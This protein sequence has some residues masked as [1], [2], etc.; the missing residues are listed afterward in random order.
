MN[1]NIQDNRHMCDRRGVK[2]KCHICE[3]I[4]CGDNLDQTCSY[5]IQGVKWDEI[6][7]NIPSVSDV[8]W[9]VGGSHRYDFG[10]PDTTHVC[11]LVS[12]EH[13]V[14]PFGEDYSNCKVRC[15]GYNFAG[16]ESLLPLDHT[17]SGDYV[18]DGEN[19]FATDSW[20][21]PKSST[22]VTADNAP[23]L[24][25]QGYVWSLAGNGRAGFQDGSPDE[26]RFNSPQDIASDRFRNVFVADT[27]NNVI[28]MISSTG[29]VSTVAGSG[30]RGAS[31]GAANSASFSSPGAVAV[32]YD[33]DDSLVLFVA[34]SANHRIRKV[35]G[36]M[37]SSGALAVGG[38]V[39]E[40]FAGRC[41]LGTESET[42]QGL[43][44]TP[45]HGFADGPGDI[46]RFDTPKGIS[47]DAD[48]MVFVADTNNH[49]IRAI[50][51]NGTVFTLAGNLEPAEE[52]IDG[53]NLEGCL[54]PCWAGVRGHRDGNLTYARFSFPTDVAVGGNHTVVVSEHHAIRRVTYR[55]E[56]S[57]MQTIDSEN[58]VVTLAGGVSEGT[59]D[60][61]G[62]EARFYA[63][64][65]VT[66][67]ADGAVYVADSVTCRLRRLASA[68]VTAVPVQCSTTLPDVVRPSGCASYN[69]PVDSLD[70]K[71]TPLAAN[72]YHNY[73]ERGERTVMGGVDAQGRRIKDCIGAPPIDRLTKAPWA[74]GTNLAV[75]DEVYYRNEDTGYG[76]Q[77]KISCPGGCFEATP[78]DVWGGSG[79]PTA[80]SG[81]AAAGSGL[82]GEA[83]SLCRA[84]LHA[85]VINN[86]NGG[87]VT[88]TLEHNL[89]VSTAGSRAGRARFGMLS[90]E[91]PP[92][93]GRVFAVEV[94]DISQ[95]E[96]QTIAGYPAANQEDGCGLSNVMPP[97]ESR[98]NGPSGVDV[99]LNS[100]L[101][102]TAY[103]YIAD[104]ANH[105]VRAISA[106]CSKVCENGGRCTA[107][108]TCTC[109]DGWTGDD[110]TTPVCAGGCG[111]R[112]L[113]VAPDTCH[114]IP[115]YSGLGAG[116]TTA[117]C[118]Q[119][120]QHGSACVAPDTCGCL[121]GWVD[122]NCTT[123]VCEQTCGN[124][125]NCTAPSHCAC[126]TDW[127]GHD[128]RVPVCTQDCNNGGFCSAPDTCTCMPGWSGH[129]CSVAVCT[130]GF[131]LPYEDDVAYESGTGVNTRV[132]P[133]W[134]EYRSCDPEQWC[135]ATNGFDCAQPHR[136][137]QQLQ[138]QWG[139]SWRGKTGWNDSAPLCAPLEIGEDVVS[140]FEYLRADGSVTGPARYTPLDPFGPVADVEEGQPREPFNTFLEPTR[141]RTPPYVYDHD[142]QVAMV[143]W[144][145]VTQ[146]RYVCANGGNC[147]SPG[148]C[149]CAYGWV[150][151]DCR[152]P[153]CHQGYYF[154]EQNYY[155]NGNER[156]NDAHVFSPFLDPLGARLD[157]VFSN[158]KYLVQEEHFNEFNE[159]MAPTHVAVETAV[160][161]DLRYLGFTWDWTYK[162][163]VT[164]PYVGE[165]GK[166][167][168]YIC[169]V[170][171]V[172]EW[173]NETYVFEHP[174]YYSR[175]MNAKTENDG[176]SYNSYWGDTWM[177]PPLHFK[178]TPLSDNTTNGWRRDGDWF[179]ANNGVNNTCTLWAEELQERAF[180]PIQAIE[181]FATERLCQLQLSSQQWVKGVCVLELDRQ[182]ET[183]EKAFDLESRHTG[184]YVLDSD[185]S[186]RAR[187]NH[188]IWNTSAEGRWWEEGGECV[189][190]VV[191]GCYNN[192]T[193]VAPDTCL[194]APGWSGFD[195]TIPLCDQFCHHHGNCTLPNT[196]TCEKG[197]TGHDCSIAVCA[198]N[199][200]NGGECVAPDV[201]KCV[202]WDSA[203][204]D[205]RKEGGW[206]VF[207]KPNGDPQN[208]GWTGYDCATPI[209]VQ[210]ERFVL[211]VESEAAFGYLDLVG[212]GF[213]G[214]AECDT[215]R[216]PFYD[217]KVVG[218]DGRTFQS[219]CINYN[220]PN[221]TRGP[222]G[223]D[224][225]TRMS[226]SHL[227][228]V[229]E[230]VQGDYVD[231]AG[232]KLEPGV[233]TDLGLNVKR[234]VRINHPN[235]LQDPNDESV[236]SYGPVM[237]G[238]GVYACYN[239]GSC[240]LPDVCTCA[241]GWGGYDCSE[242]LC[243]H[244]QPNGNVTGCENGGICVAKDDCQCIRTTSLL[245]EVYENSPI[246]ETGWGGT[247]CSMPVCVQ[248]FFDPLCNDLPEAPG[249][250][251][252]YRCLNGGNCTA[253]DHCTCEQGWSGY[254]CNTP[255]CEMVASDLARR[256]LSTQDEEKVHTLES[257]PCGLKDIFGYIDFEGRQQLRGNC[258][259]PN[260]C[261]C[262]CFNWYDV[263]K[264]YNEGSQCDGPWQD[265]MYTSRD[266]LPYANQ[267]GSRDCVVGYEGHLDH[268]DRFMSCHLEIYVPHWTERY[269]IEL[270]AG[271][272][273]TSTVV[274][275]M[276]H[277]IR[278]KLRERYLLAK[279][280]RRRS[281]R[282]SED[283]FEDS[284]Q[285][286]TFA[287]K[288]R[289]AG[290]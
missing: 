130:Q 45:Q 169:S 34:D 276:Y 182:C 241:D 177:W 137:Q 161:G 290:R 110:C 131:F 122:A 202:Q 120:C 20:E 247:D 127:G 103:L 190:H 10:N 175:Y 119:S 208:T 83:S 194:C 27:G 260:Q 191:R 206:P 125:G 99:Y 81:A 11:L 117:L 270:I 43:P 36:L 135:R 107:P 132:G 215:V 211:N 18:D 148:V 2:A 112:E 227:C 109:Q 121:S 118:V 128:C 13:C 189:D 170:R 271:S 58:R 62:P 281:R 17:Y 217:E 40:C 280:E 185:L 95:M 126:P 3:D 228:R 64:E 66:V 213:Q 5:Q 71:A 229:T 225:G 216:C 96:V 65:G 16:Q 61:P 28:R 124:G 252:C 277:L 92:D 235:I 54:S 67:A 152:T 236:W 100:S 201:C 14:E 163:N 223:D 220:D 192:G 230:W 108:E 248:G 203:W 22:E 1:S 69:P 167:G 73:L 155:V 240:I 188:S 244:L 272:C 210:A 207:R 30:E 68:E 98:F 284:D 287:A 263:D 6:S 93:Q 53:G 205:G 136:A 113:C 265:P 24:N 239:G 143:S 187:V 157:G 162:V 181:T 218:N 21:Y 226:V 164:S 105:A 142:R 279:A 55:N 150:G 237:R 195:C 261:T 178:S 116:C 221:A 179:V 283:D 231:A 141:G 139:V 88:V 156:T 256:E 238:E 15:W 242:P 269:S 174:N 267:Y 79:E 56:P 82:Y 63:P 134:N 257:D 180:P 94:F 196:C 70:Y 147:T 50:Y 12:G 144:R 160:H 209:C 172:T 42:L 193:C 145:E 48:G 166:Q 278:K 74:N 158:P 44:A 84:A 171:S 222:G 115:G 266:I 90:T 285:A 246:G 138:P 106:V 214:E 286:A 60:G 186:Y 41:G 274:F 86:I 273:V 38:G 168:G 243:R 197:W 25:P 282:S 37:T 233:G 140:P 52:A 200:N 199:C 87:L 275:I 26:A 76:T 245:H 289:A 7:H 89:R 176:I 47:V 29:Q 91:L 80:G 264:C 165:S 101:S 253:P 154:P 97:Q 204:R 183:P 129:D 255:V 104:T 32:W 33:A 224:V 59:E 234:H 9:A 146:G 258:T 159:D 114:C 133:V 77:I 251:G 219:G 85:G 268:L 262:L 35:T 250:E 49:L 123:P 232:L 254:D 8:P 149:V 46:A 111:T 72:I 75:D 212:H 4:V 23:L 102:D 39:V 288:A 57:T 51:P 184:V 19:E 78:S 259:L 249:G 153:V 151:F 173:E 198:Q 31:E